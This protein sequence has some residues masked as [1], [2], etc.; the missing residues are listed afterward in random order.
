[1]EECGNKDKEIEEV[2]EFIDYRQISIFIN[3]NHIQYRVSIDECHDNETV[4]RFK[5][6]KSLAKIRSYGVRHYKK[7][8][9]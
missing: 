7:T 2:K 5:N 6:K 3:E 1:M 9:A 4:Y 8:I